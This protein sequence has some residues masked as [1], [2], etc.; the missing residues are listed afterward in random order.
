MFTNNCLGDRKCHFH[1]R[2]T[3]GKQIYS[4]V[5]VTGA[6]AMLLP[7]QTQLTPL[8]SDLD[9]CP[10]FFPPVPELW[11]MGMGSRCRTPAHVCPSLC[12]S[13]RER[14]TR[15]WPLSA[16]TIRWST[17]QIISL[18]TALKKWLSR[19]LGLARNL[20]PSSLR[21]K[22]FLEG[23]SRRW[24]CDGIRVL[25]QPTTNSELIVRC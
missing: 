5:T 6:R 25:I 7:G 3:W 10:F 13:S 1:D 19:G 8:N 22:E 18:P 24:K 2:I 11:R 12:A 21:D 4:P 9:V 16:A 23:P 17:Y 15:Q 14:W 20:S